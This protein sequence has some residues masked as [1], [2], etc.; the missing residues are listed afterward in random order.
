MYSTS[1][2]KLKNTWETKD[3]YKVVA[4]DNL[5]MTL[6]VTGSYLAVFNDD[7]VIRIRD[8]NNN[9]VVKLK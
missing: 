3:D 7:K 2:G 4:Y 9:V 8:N 1:T 5:K 6:D